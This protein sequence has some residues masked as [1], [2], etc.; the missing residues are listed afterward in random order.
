MEGRQQLLFTKEQLK[1][2][3]DVSRQD[4]DGSTK[5][6]PGLLTNIMPEQKQKKENQRAL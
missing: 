6:D 1:H 3:K 2:L 5:R 4:G